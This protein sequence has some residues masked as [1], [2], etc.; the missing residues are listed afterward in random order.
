M[1]KLF[2]KRFSFSFF[3]VLLFLTV[4]TVSFKIKNSAEDFKTV[5]IGNQTWMA[6]N[7]NVS[8]FRNGDII[9]EANTKELWIKA[10][11]ER[12]PAWCYY[13][14]KTAN[15]L[16]HG[17][18]YNWF[19]VDDARGIAPEGWHVASNT[20]WDKLTDALGGEMEA[21]EK[22]KKSKPN[23]KAKI[24]LKSFDATMSGMCDEEQNFYFINFIGYFW[25]TTQISSNDAWAKYISVFGKSFSNTNDTKT[26]GFPI[27]CV[28]D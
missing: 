4:F 27:R 11:R 1:V 9:P 28:K 26:S 8:K 13:Q 14:N 21:G 16:I 5:I 2:Y 6:E 7:L 20:D 25:S 18:L 23:K 15:G 22:L 3:T 10:S 19:A 24:E 17:K 12:K